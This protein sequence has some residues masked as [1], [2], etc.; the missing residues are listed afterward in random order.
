MQHIPLLRAG[1]PYQSLT[2][3]TVSHISTGEPIAQVSQANRG[4]IARDLNAMTA[5]QRALMDFSVDQL[6]AISRKAAEYFMH[7]DLPLGNG[8]QSAEDYVRDLSSTSGLPQVL[9]RNNMEKIRLVMDQ[10]EA[11]LGG[12]T[13]GL[14]LSI[15]DNGYGIQQQRPLSY[16]CQTRSLGAI[17]PSNSPGVHSLWQP[18]IPLKVPLVLKPGSEEP[19]TPYR[20]AQAFIA[21]GCPPQ[22][23]S[24]YPTDYAGAGEILMHCGRTMFF[25]T[26][27]TIEAWKDDPRVQLHGTGFSKILFGTDQ[28]DQW[29]DHLELLERSV[30]ENGGRSCI[31]AS[32]IWTPAQGRPIAAALAQRLAQIE[33]TALEDPKAQ[34][35]A[36]TRPAFAASISAMIDQQL[37]IPGAQDLTAQYRNGERLVQKDGCTYLLPTVIW[38][39]DPAHPLA[40]IEFLFPCVSVVQVPQDQIVNAMGPTLVATAITQDDDLILDLLAASQ[41]D[42]LN[43]GPI[44][45]NKISWDQPHEGNLFEFLYRQRAFQ[46]V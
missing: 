6:M 40:Q 9:C 46:R 24:Y 25:G 23:F 10:V 7:G 4:L 17:L 44:P 20:V 18:A 45:T 38:C 31:N 42:R 1:Q 13:R 30:V 8:T 43:L 35:A 15:L 19:W 12:L 11:V 16:V 2:T 33:A 22:A 39:E 27:S 32:G 14:D 29:P 3:Q 36:F 34:L 5:N 21:A 37:K 28:L 41:I 26:S